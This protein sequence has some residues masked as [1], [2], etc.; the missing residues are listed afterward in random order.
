MGNNNKKTSHEE[1]KE[2]LQQLITMTEEDYFVDI[3]RTIAYNGRKF[4][5]RL[6]NPGNG[7]V[8]M[9][10]RRIGVKGAKLE[11]IYNGDPETERIFKRFTQWAEA[12]Q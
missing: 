12:Q 11:E 9:R 10:A 6:V 1:V 7:K 3:E 5:L 8:I 4:D 2:D